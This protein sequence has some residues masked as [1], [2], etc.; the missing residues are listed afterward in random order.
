MELRSVLTNQTIPPHLPL[1]HL[2]QGGGAGGA[3]R[4]GQAGAEG[5]KAAQEG[6]RCCVCELGRLSRDGWLLTTTLAPA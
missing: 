6:R 3:G 1:P 2:F 4:G 5:G